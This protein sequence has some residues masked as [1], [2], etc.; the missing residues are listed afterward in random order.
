[1]LQNNGLS[2][3]AL[4]E[5]KQ[6]EGIED[7]PPKDGDLESLHSQRTSISSNI[8]KNSNHSTRKRLTNT[9]QL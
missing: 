5:G 3:A 9:A 1:M 2:K 4:I 7:D 8:S 6:Q